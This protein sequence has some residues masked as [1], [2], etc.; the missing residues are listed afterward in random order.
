M[1]IALVFIV[2]YLIGSIPF[3]YLIVYYKE[4]VDI[5]KTGSG[6]ID[7]T[8]VLR[9]A[10]KFAAALTW[11]LDTLKGAVAV[12][13]VP[14]FILGYDGASNWEVS[15]AAIL[16]IMGHCFPVWLRFRGGKGVATLLGIVLMFAPLGFACFVVVFALIVITTRYISIGSI[17]G[18]VLIPLLVWWFQFHF[19]DGFDYRIPVVSTA[20]CSL[21]V[22]F[23]HRENI[24]RLIKG[25]ERKLGRIAVER[26]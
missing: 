1:R 26:V 20:I 11:F 7:A 6:G 22:I 4:D 24:T 13:I 15:A 9:R 21:I 10:G 19:V 18:C 14:Y 17:I 8:N 25:E 23:M 5:R 3:G 2:A 16:T 12:S